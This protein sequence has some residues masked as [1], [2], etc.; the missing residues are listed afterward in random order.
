MSQEAVPGEAGILA[1]FLRS[2]EGSQSYCDVPKSQAIS[3]RQNF[4]ALPIHQLPA[5]PFFLSPL[6]QCSLSLR[7]ARLSWTLICNPVLTV[8]STRHIEQ[9][10]SLCINQH[11]WWKE[12]LVTKVG[13]NPDLFMCV[14]GFKFL[15]NC[16]LSKLYG[17][18][19][20]YVHRK[21]KNSGREKQTKLVVS[22]E[23][24]LR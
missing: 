2:H 15:L 7:W 9:L 12:P 20:F 22:R 3:R 17:S 21:M 18:L 24:K 13:S 14:A 11:P 10:W 8:A 19:D 4:L 1:G 23:K 6:L 5:L 16:R